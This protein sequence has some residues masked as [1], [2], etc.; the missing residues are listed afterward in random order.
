MAAPS[1]K[2]SG[3]LQAVKGAFRNSAA[4]S[5]WITSTGGTISDSNVKLGRAPQDNPIVSSSGPV[6]YLRRGRYQNSSAG[7]ETTFLRE[8]EVVADIVWS[9]NRMSSNEGYPQMNY[10]DSMID[11]FEAK[12][13]SLGQDYSGQFNAISSPDLDERDPADENIH[14]CEIAFT[15]LY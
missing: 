9:E 3:F 11:E 13:Y 10:L 12:G 6:A 8:L 2:I 15:I 14:H 4:F 1:G 7:A 5:Q